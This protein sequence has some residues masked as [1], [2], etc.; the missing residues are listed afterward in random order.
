[1]KSQRNPL[2]HSFHPC[3]NTVVMG[4]WLF[5]NIWFL[6]RVFVWIEFSIAYN[7]SRVDCW[8]FSNVSANIT[9][10]IFRVN[11]CEVVRKPQFPLPDLYKDSFSPLIFNP[12]D[13]S[14]GVCRNG[15]KLSALDSA[16]L[17][18]KRCTYYSFCKQ[19]A[20]SIG[21]LGSI[22]LFLKL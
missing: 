7:L 21:K 3:K 14:C 17:R 9:V 13:G 12:W 11:I 6:F 16:Y 18:Q 10:A 4:R 19:C 8:R 22:M 1:M 2:L 20:L 15:S 5:I